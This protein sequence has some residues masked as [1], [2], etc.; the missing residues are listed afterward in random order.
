MSSLTVRQTSRPF[1]LVS[2]VPHPG[3]LALHAFGIGAVDDSD[4]RWRLFA[5]AI[6]PLLDHRDLCYAV[7]RDDLKL[8]AFLFYFAHSDA[9][10]E[11]AV[12]RRL[13]PF[14]VRAL[15]ATHFAMRNNGRAATAMGWLG[16][17]VASCRAFLN[18]PFDMNRSSFF[19]YSF[20]FPG[21]S[22]GLSESQKV[23][24]PRT[25]IPS[26]LTFPCLSCPRR[27]ITPAG[28]RA[29]SCPRGTTT[30]ASFRKST[31][32]LKSTPTWLI[33]QALLFGSGKLLHE[34]SS[35]LQFFGGN[36]SRGRLSVA[37]LEFSRAV[38]CTFYN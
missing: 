3:L 31:P 32:S 33:S 23:Y 25:S 2:Q 28:T 19:L 35:G 38:I 4:P 27:S 18:W 22:I 7:D 26:M 17:S 24:A 6:S 12:A 16:V 29:S 20:S 13:R 1:P 30:A 36:F 9:E 21:A 34:D 11:T 8:F 14:E 10:A 15:V 37:K 5:A